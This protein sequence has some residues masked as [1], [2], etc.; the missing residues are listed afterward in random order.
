MNR[1]RHCRTCV[2]CLVSNV[3]DKEPTP[4]PSLP[5]E[6]RR[7]GGEPEEE[8]GHCKLDVTPV[9][10][11]STSSTFFTSK[12]NI[13]IDAFQCPPNP[14]GILYSWC[15]LHPRVQIDTVRFEFPG[16][17]Q[18][19]FRAQTPGQNPGAGEED[20][21]QPRNLGAS[22]VAS[23]GGSAVQQHVSAGW[24]IALQL[25]LK[26]VRSGMP[27]WPEGLDDPF[28]PDVPAIGQTVRTMELGQVQSGLVHDLQHLL[29]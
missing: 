7:Q 12:C 20:P 24:S 2:T 8:Q 1:W 11:C 19:R 14:P 22:S 17:L 9:S 29:R 3:A 5:P 10:T 6:D 28:P 4:G 21:G 26:G 18:D 15:A 16:L 23:P 13:S 25:L 27:H